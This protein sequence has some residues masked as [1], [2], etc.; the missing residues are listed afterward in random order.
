MNVETIAFNFHLL[1]QRARRERST[2]YDSMLIHSP[3]LKKKVI[4]R[5]VFFQFPSIFMLAITLWFS[6]ML[7][8]GCKNEKNSGSERAFISRELMLLDSARAA[9]AI[10]DDD[11]E[12]F[13]QRIG[14]LDMSLQMQR[15]YPA[16]ATRAQVLSDYRKFLQTDVTDFATNEAVVLHAVFEEIKTLCDQI[17]PGIFPD[18]LEL[19]KTN[20]RHYGNGV[21]YTRENRIIIPA[22]ELTYLDRESLREVLLHEVFHIYSRQ[23]PRKRDALYALIG[24]HDLPGELI[25]PSAISS[26]LLLNPDGVDMS[27]AIELAMAKADTALCVPII[28]ANAPAYLPERERYFEYVDFNLYPVREQAD[29]SFVAMTDSLGHS[30]IRLQEQPD[31]FRQIRDN[32]FYIIHPDEILADNFKWLVL[33]RTGEEKYKPERFSAAGQALLQAIETVLKK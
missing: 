14:K 11:A 3:K 26:R 17:A 19:I 23:H 9:R 22:N 16:E 10:L 20:G 25:L 27:Y 12:D 31:F 33:A 6:G 29:G 8:T 2:R 32:T 30:P 13:F 24:F 21:Y 7:L 4:Q 5:K 28:T 1:L 18:A 15:N